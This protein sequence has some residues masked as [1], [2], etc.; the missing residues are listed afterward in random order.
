MEEEF[1]LTHIFSHRKEVKGFPSCFVLFI[2][3]V[4]P[5]KQTNFSF[6]KFPQVINKEIIII[7]SLTHMMCLLGV[8]KL[9]AKLNSCLCLKIVLL[10]IM[11]GIVLNIAWVLLWCCPVYWFSFTK[12]HAEFNTI[13]TCLI[14]NIIH[15]LCL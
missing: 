11:P 9:A 8:L 2:I 4:W 15:I 5:N 1:S 12:N 13:K 3:I 7:F 6:Y 10:S 14:S